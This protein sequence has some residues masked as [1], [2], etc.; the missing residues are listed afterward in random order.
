MR[1]FRRAAAAVEEL[2]AE[3]T[4]RRAA[5]GTL[6]Q[7]PG[8]GEA[9]AR[10][11]EEACRGEVPGYLARLEAEQAAG[12]WGPG[13]GGALRQLLRGDCHVHSDW[14]DGG[15]PIREM[16][17]TARELG[18]AYIVLTD[19]S[20]RLRVANGLS[21]ERLREQLGVLAE[22]HRELAPF[23]VLSGIE[24]DILE[25]GTLDQTEELLGDLDVVVASVHSKLRMPAEEMT[26]RMLRAIENPH[27]DILGHCT[28]RYVAGK[29]RPESAFDAEVVFA[30]CARL[31]K[32]VEINSRVERLD[33]PRR[34]LRLAN[35]MGCLF[36][37]DSD[38][39]A[40]GQL[41]WVSNGTV[42]AEECGVA[43]ERIVNTWTADELVAWARG[44]GGRA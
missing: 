9:T 4:A 35:E 17:E 3:E 20:P 2:G 6:R 38:A 27:M 18:L 14:S 19:H 12:A 7:I 10:V 23:R 44:H 8:V 32:A 33:P 22:L 25:D 30:A 40:P 24:V 26:A 39:H 37:V 11:I 43:A 31:G 29:Q 21:A 36:A 15:S 42:R 1:A 28:G 16:A 5:E 34:M 41:D 13:H